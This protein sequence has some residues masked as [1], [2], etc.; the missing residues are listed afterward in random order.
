MRFMKDNV[1]YAVSSPFIKKRVFIRHEHKHQF[2]VHKTEKRICRPSAI[3]SINGH[4]RKNINVDEKR[5]KG[6]NGQEKIPT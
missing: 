4:K 5:R 1:R 6:R 3:Y 2:Q